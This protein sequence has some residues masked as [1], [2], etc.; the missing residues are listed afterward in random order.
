MYILLSSVKHK[1]HTSGLMQKFWEEWGVD[2]CKYIFIYVYTLA[3]ILSFWLIFP[4][5]FKSHFPPRQKINIQHFNFK[6]VF[7]VLDL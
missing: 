2:V 5:N 7:A 6:N 4:F 3:L 1:H